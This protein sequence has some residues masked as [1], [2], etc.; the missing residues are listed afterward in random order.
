MPGLDIDRYTEYEID[1]ANRKVDTWKDTQA[2]T[3]I[4]TYRK[5]N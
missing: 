5:M 4:N 2:D 1:K 3:Y